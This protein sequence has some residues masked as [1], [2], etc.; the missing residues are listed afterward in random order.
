[1]TEQVVEI[2]DWS[3]LNEALLP[4][5]RS[6][7]IGRFRSSFVFRG[8]VDADHALKNGLLRLEHDDDETRFLEKSILKSFMKYAHQQGTHESSHW[9]WVSLAQH[10]GLPT[11]LLDWT[12]S[13]YVALHFAVGTIPDARADGAVWQ[14][15]A[16]A[17]HEQLPEEL[18]GQLGSF[19]MFTAEILNEMAPNFETFDEMASNM[20]RSFALFFEPPSL[21]ERIVNQYAIF[22][23]LSDAARRFDDWF[24]EHGLTYTKFIIPGRLKWEFRDRLDLLNITERVL[25]PGLDG[26]SAWLKRYYYNAARFLEADPPADNAN[27]EQI[28]PEHITDEGSREEKE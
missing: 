9:T 17:V 3:H 22:S 6:R 26:L 11:R 4:L 10:H 12:W 15:D 28:S 5:E 27:P 25:F 7:T 13:P 20:G 21:D 8:V 18:R 1:M 19:L 16:Q 24:T 23:V 2:R 14:V